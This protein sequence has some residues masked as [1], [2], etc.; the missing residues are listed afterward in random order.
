MIGKIDVLA[1]TLLSRKNPADI[2]YR[3]YFLYFDPNRKSI[4][5]FNEGQVLGMMAECDVDFDEAPLILFAINHADSLPLM[6]HRMLV[7]QKKY[8]ILSKWEQRDAILKVVRPAD[9]RHLRL[10]AG[11]RELFRKR[12][13]TVPTRFEMPD[14]FGYRIQEGDATLAFA[15]AVWMVENYAGVVT[16][17]EP[18]QRRKGHGRSCLGT[19]TEKLHLRGVTP[20]T[21]GEANHASEEAFLASVGYA[22]LDKEF[23]LCHGGLK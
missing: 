11:Q 3:Y 1:E 14:S 7:P 9:Q 21:F 4:R 10:Y 16:N 23:F 6:L 20:L 2:L 15:R 17:T 22:P 19:L 8:L 13:G 12:V 5:T 18:T